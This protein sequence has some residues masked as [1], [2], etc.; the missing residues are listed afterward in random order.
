M[1]SQESPTATMT[2]RRLH[3]SGQPEQRTMPKR[4]RDVFKRNPA[5][6]IVAIRSR[7]ICPQ[8]SN[9]GA[10]KRRKS[11]PRRRSDPL[12]RT[13]EESGPRGPVPRRPR[14]R[15]SLTGWG[16]GE[17]TRPH[18]DTSVYVVSAV[19][20]ALDPTQPV[21]RRSPKLGGSPGSGQSSSPSTDSTESADGTD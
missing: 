12:P 18:A 15:D 7:A 4:P 16:R 13:A 11:S 6:G 17:V 20:V 14:R 19:L 2:M 1:A 3:E 8:Y 5:T 21:R 10:K 9:R